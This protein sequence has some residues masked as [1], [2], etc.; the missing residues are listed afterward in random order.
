MIV[1]KGGLYRGYALVDVESIP[2]APACVRIDT[3]A[4]VGPAVNPRVFHTHV[5]LL[6]DVVVRLECLPH[7][8]MARVASAMMLP[9]HGSG[10]RVVSNSELH[11]HRYPVDVSYYTYDNYPD[12]GHHINVEVGVSFDEW[13]ELQQ[14]IALNVLG[15]ADSRLIDLYG[16]ME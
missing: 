9:L 16:R 7:T 6:T 4:I 5:R 14:C 13:C 1:S 10:G 11:L 8:L 12:A 2:T 15:P 3:Y